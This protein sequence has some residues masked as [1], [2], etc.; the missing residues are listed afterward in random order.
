MNRQPVTRQQISAQRFLARRMAHALVRRDVAMHDDPLRAQSLSLVIG[1]V[2][3]TM[4]IAACAVLTLMRPRGVPASAPI[5]MASESGALYV[6]VDDTLHPVLNLASARLIARSAVGPVPASEASI[7]RAKR[8]PMMGIPGAPASIGEPVRGSAWT[9][10][11]GERTVVAVDERGLDPF[12]ATRPVLVTPHGESAAMT[13]LLYDGHRAEVDL[14]N[15]A[16]IRALRL[17]GVAPVAVSRALLDV[18]PE[19]PAIAVPRIA[20][21]GAAGPAALG[22]A[23]IGTVVRVRRAEIVEHYVVLRDGIQPVGE[24]AADLI[25]FAYDRDATPV[26]AVAPAAIA[27]LPIVT[28]LPV[29]TFPQHARTPVGRADGLAVCAQWRPGVSASSNTVVLSGDWSHVQDWDAAVLAQADGAGPNVD[30]VVIP[31]GASAYV[32]SARISGDG[33]TAGPRFLV[34]DAGVLF[35][36][37]DDDAATFLGLGLAP[38]AAP[39]A[40]LARLPRGPELS[41]DAASVAR[42]GLPTPS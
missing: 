15:P 6:R 13:Y 39:W 42:D 28:G 27:A 1:C 36:V 32:R 29:A 34:S 20:R 2:L 21:V 4:V 17:D 37:H 18:V 8:G 19:V 14:R 10:C 5:V 26:A 35:G 22:D 24:V 23:P 3:A 7:A 33:G 11:D 41:T 16:V 9:V 12:D 30:A 40:V 31:G 38:R 25:R